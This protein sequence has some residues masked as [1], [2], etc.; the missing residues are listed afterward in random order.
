MCVIIEKTYF[1]FKML[2]IFMFS[3][4]L[5]DILVV[6]VKVDPLVLIKKDETLSDTY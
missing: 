1:I 3:H 5:V 6:V 2:T 4:V